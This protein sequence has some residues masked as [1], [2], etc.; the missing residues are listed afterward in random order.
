MAERGA[1]GCVTHK[2]K[3]INVC[4]EHREH[5]NAETLRLLM[6]LFDAV[7]KDACSKTYCALGR[8]GMVHLAWLAVRAHLDVE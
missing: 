7:Q 3:F 1:C 8:G 5:P 4:E 6:A 2:G